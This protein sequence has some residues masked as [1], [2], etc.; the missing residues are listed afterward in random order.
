M[1][2]K[3]IGLGLMKRKHAEQTNHGDKD[4]NRDANNITHRDWGGRK[5][6]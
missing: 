6:N 2:G 5:K 1:Y 3:Q 4:S